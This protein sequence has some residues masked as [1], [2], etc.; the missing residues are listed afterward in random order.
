ML[1]GKCP[2]SRPLSC[3]AQHDVNLLASSD[4]FVNEYILVDSRKFESQSLQEIP[5]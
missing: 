1:V 4:W 3:N 2:P 5:T